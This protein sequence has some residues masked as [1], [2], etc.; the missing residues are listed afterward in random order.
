MID[1][2][3][4]TYNGAS[5]LE[6][7]L[8]SL[9]GQTYSDWRLLVRDDGSSDETVEILRKYGAMDQRVVI[10]EDDAKR[11][12]A[13]GNFLNLLELS[14]ANWIMFCD[15]DDVWLEDKIQT[16]VDAI[17]ETNA[18]CAV[19]CNAYS[20]KNGDI[21]SDKVTLIHP[22]NLRDTLFLNGGIQGC[23]IILNK[24]LKNKLFPLPEYVCM[25]DHLVTLGAITFGSL[26]YVDRSLMLYRQH[27][28][29]VTGN[30]ETRRFRRFLNF[31]M[32]G[33]PVID[34]N[35][36]KGVKSFYDAYRNRLNQS[37]LALFN[38]YFAF[39]DSRSRLSRLVIVVRYRFKV[40]TYM[41]SLLAKT[42]IRK[43]LNNP[44]DE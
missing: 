15:Q 44:G 16:M 13:S 6:N 28:A 11:L 42:I 17:S 25:H 14:T 35:H 38:A 8:L 4:A 18:P 10:V 19:Y 39:A 2:L 24:E 40:G 32:Y 37:Q 34:F 30:Y 27:N 9:I 5:F 20:Y 21:V 29:N 23:S 7:Q 12:G 26:R 1:I 36:H 43:S 22:T 33:K 3:M 31:F 41:S